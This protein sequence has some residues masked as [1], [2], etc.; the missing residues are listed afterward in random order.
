MDEH[1]MSRSYADLSE[2][3]PTSVPKDAW[4]NPA[5]WQF[6]KEGVAH[7]R[8]ILS[9]DLIDAYRALRGRLGPRGWSDIGAPYQFYRELLELCL[10]E[11]LMTTMRTVIG[12]PMGVHL[13]LTDWVS[14]ERD[15]HSD[16]YLNPETVGDRYVAAWFALEDIHPDSGPFQYVPGSHLW[17]VIRRQ[18]VFAQL[19]E[20]ERNNP[21][22]PWTTEPWIARACEEEIN[23]RAADVVT[24]LPKRGDVLL[25]HAFLIHRGSRPTTPGRPRRSLIAHYSSINH[26][27]DMTFAPYGSGH[28]ALFPDM[29]TAIAKHGYPAP[30]L[31]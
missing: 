16:H 14:T 15:W 23:R 5:G 24:Y 6:A 12:E 8:G 2:L 30:T 11:P 26:R 20:H 25:W 27:P 19:T 21:D 7:L 31:P 3:V 13:N 29:R 4:S 22:W 28:Y 17:P 1:P 9:D 18:R 10:Y